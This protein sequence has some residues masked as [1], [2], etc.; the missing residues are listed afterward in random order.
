M[1]DVCNLVISQILSHKILMN[2]SPGLM[3]NAVL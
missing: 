2:Y 3:K 1:S